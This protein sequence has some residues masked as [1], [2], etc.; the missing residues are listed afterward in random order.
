MLKFVALSTIEF[1]YPNG[2]K[3]IHLLANVHLMPL[4][5]QSK[6]ALNI[7]LLGNQ[8]ESEKVRKWLD[9]IT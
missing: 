8:R 1:D 5:M 3:L 4:N 9:F 2:L 6:H 7:N